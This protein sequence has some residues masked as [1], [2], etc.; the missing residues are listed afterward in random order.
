MVHKFLLFEGTSGLTS[1]IIEIF[2]LVSRAEAVITVDTSIVHIASAFNKP[3][4]AL[5]VNL[6][7]FYSQYLPLSDNYRVV[8]SP[9]EGDPISKI[10]VEDVVNNYV[11]LQLAL[12]QSPGEART[13]ND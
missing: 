8:T 7:N 5:Y 10:P 6:Q 13:D 11:S 1:P 3:I 9:G 2:S 12:H 4:L